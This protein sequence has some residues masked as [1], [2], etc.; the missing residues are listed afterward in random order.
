MLI[1]QWSAFYDIHC[2]NSVVLV[3]TSGPIGVIGSAK[4]F[5]KVLNALGQRC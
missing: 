5:R 4:L 3:L 1:T 2:R